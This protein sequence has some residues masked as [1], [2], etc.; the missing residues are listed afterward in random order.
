MVEPSGGGG[1]VGLICESG[2]WSATTISVDIRVPSIASCKY[3]AFLRI[4]S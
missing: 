2:L 4:P 1:I 3:F